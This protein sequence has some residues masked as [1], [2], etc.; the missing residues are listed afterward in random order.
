MAAY[1]QDGSPSN[2]EQ[3]GAPPTTPG[4]SAD[5]RTWATVC[6][7][8]TFAGH[9]FPFGHILGP[10]VVWLIKKEEYPLVADQGKEAMN[11]Q[12]SLT[13]Y[14]LICLVLVFVFIGIILLIALWV[15]DVV[16]TIVAAIRANKGE[17]YRYP[18]TIRFI[19]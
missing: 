8:A 17:P 15:A 14:S 2:Y 10:M 18:L 4:S 16:L 19:K 13:I 6:H 12:N 5:E 1:D 9:V 11:F 3:E 7:L